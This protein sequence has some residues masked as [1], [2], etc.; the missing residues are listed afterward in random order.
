MDAMPITVDRRVADR[1]AKPSF[2]SLAL[3]ST[4]GRR[5]GGRR[6]SDQIQYV[7]RYDRHLL[8]CT[9]ATIVLCALD[10]AFTLR[11][12]ARGAVEMNAFMAVLIEDDIFKFVSVKL[13]LTSL[14]IFM[15][16]IH[17]NVRIWR[18]KVRVWH[19]QY[20]ILAGYMALIT[21]ELALLRVAY[22]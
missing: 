5:A 2:F 14:A 22:S 8:W 4:K 21:Y 17:H 16:V 11:L 3:L 1:R 18:G 10:A 12:L 13:S 7:D 20:L 19:L 6:A 15:L 9:I